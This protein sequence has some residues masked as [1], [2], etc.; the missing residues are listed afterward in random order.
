MIAT[1]DSYGPGGRI[2]R[3]ENPSG[4]YP[5]NRY[6]SLVLSA[7]AHTEALAY[8]ADS[9]RRLSDL[10]AVELCC[11]GGAA[12][13]TLKAAGLGRVEA[14]DVN[15]AALA[16]CRRNAEINDVRL[17]RVME[18]NLLA[19]PAQ[20]EPIDLLIC[21]PPC[22]RSDQAAA[23]PTPDIRIAIDG[24]QDGLSFFA[25]LFRTAVAWL[26]P[27]GRLVFIAASS[28]AFRKLLNELDHNFPNQ[29]RLDQTTPVAQPFVPVDGDLGRATLARVDRGEAFAWEG[30]DG[31]VWRLTW[32]FVV[33]TSP[34]R[35][36]GFDRRLLLVPRSYHP[37]AASYAAAVRRFGTMGFEL[38]AIDFAQTP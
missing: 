30:E 10:R 34:E 4:L 7:A 20:L 21:N 38:P 6:Q 29:W 19:P 5:V 14:F 24:G 2:L 8:A 32:V 17:D 37:P 31:W 27:G 23:V 22:G 1:I 16:A 25:P 26:C 28:L 11:G 18:Y 36:G 9:G 35:M 15:A 3:F 13:I 33:T 12:A